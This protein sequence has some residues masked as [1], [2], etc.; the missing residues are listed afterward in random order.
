MRRLNSLVLLAMFV[1]PICTSPITY[2]IDIAPKDN[3]DTYIVELNTTVTFNVTGYEK[4]EET[5][6]EVE[7]QIDKLWWNFDKEILAKVNSSSSSI[8][9]KA[10]KPGASNL[11]AIGMVKN[12][13]CTKTITILVKDRVQL[14]ETPAP[15]T[16]Q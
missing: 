13:S 10:T 8:T 5:T 6:A 16:T 14:E 1:L 3:N 11:T 4:N 7:V 2:R 9:L 15:L 12:Q